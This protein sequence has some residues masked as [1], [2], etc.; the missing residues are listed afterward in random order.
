MR[1]LRFALT[2]ASLIVT[3]AFAVPVA[4]KPGSEFTVLA[5]PQPSQCQYGVMP[6]WGHVWH[7]DTTS[8][9]SRLRIVAIDRC[10]LL[11]PCR[12]VRRDPI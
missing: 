1:A 12:N 3:T 5:T 11:G 10:A 6:I 7:L 4:P 8:T 2:A 9:V